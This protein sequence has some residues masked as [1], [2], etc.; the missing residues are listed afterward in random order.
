MAWE[1]L[2]KSQ[3]MYLR[4]RAGSRILGGLYALLGAVFAL[5]GFASSGSLPARLAIGLPMGLF[6]IIVAGIGL[7]LFLG[8]VRVDQG[9]VHYRRFAKVRFVPRANIAGLEVALNR[10]M[11]R[12]QDT[13]VIVLSDGGRVPLTLVAAYRTSAGLAWLAASRDAAVDALAVA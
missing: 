12:S 8:S 2:M 9:G 6:G 1:T 10:G 13:L 4:A 3:V 11:F 7:R 5:S